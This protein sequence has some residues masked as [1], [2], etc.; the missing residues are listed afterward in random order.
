[1]NAHPTPVPEEELRRTLAP[2]PQ[3]P[4]QS[5]TLPGPTGES[6]R[7]TLIPRAPLLCL[8]PSA[9]QVEAQVQAVTALGGIAMPA[10]GLPPEAL[11]TLQGVSAAL[12]WGAEDEARPF[13]L[14]LSSRPGPIL[15]LITDL[16][17]LG[18]VMLERVTCIDT[19]A[20][21]GNA[22]LLVEVSGG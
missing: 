15:P 16:P 20:S 18:H 1:M 9:A 8:G 21:G 6:N 14:A 11:A 4:V 17:D 5:E 7:L 3:A 12:H 19:T 2:R 22:Q 13:A 10:P